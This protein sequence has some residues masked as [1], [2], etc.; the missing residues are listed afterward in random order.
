MMFRFRIR[1]SHGC[2]RFQ[3]ICRHNSGAEA[4]AEVCEALGIIYPTHASIIR[5][6]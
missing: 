5:L 3:A 1:L 4:L 2:S 6:P